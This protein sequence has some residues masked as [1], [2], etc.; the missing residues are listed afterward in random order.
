MPL[1]DAATAVVE[2]GAAVEQI[3]REIRDPA[4]ARAVDDAGAEREADEAVAFAFREEL[5]F[6]ADLGAV[7]FH[8]VVDGERR[9]LVGA[10]GRILAVNGSAAEIDD[11]AHAGVAGGETKRGRHALDL[12]GIADRGVNDGGA[13]GESAGHRVNVEGVGEVRFDR[14]TLR[15]GEARGTPND[16]GDRGSAAQLKVFDE[17]R[18]NEA[19]GSDD[20]DFHEAAV[21]GALSSWACA[22]SSGVSQGC[23]TRVRC[24]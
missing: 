2:P 17:A 16:R 18:A 6:G 9:G 22:A 10:V 1:Q 23:S 11:P 24:A 21:T 14:E 7:V 5:V 19:A 4:G 20:S 15:Q 8:R 13:A 12:R 3:G